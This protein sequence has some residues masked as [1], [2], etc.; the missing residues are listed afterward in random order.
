RGRQSQRPKPAGPELLVELAGEPARPPLSWPLQPHRPEPDLN[1]VLS[2]VIGQR[3]FGRKQGKLPGAP[4]VLVEAL[5]HP[6]PGGVLAVVDLAEVQKRL[7][8]DPAAGTAP[9][10]DDAPVA[11][12]LAVLDPPREAQVHVKGFYADLQP[13]EGAWSSLHANSNCQPLKRL[14]F[15]PA[16]NLKNPRQL[17]QLRKLGYGMFGH[18]DAGVLHVR[19]AIDTKDPAQEKLIREITEEVV[20]L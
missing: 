2:G 10:L 1:A 5:D 14:A 9:A 6:A 17:L 11:M 16:K 7:L 3:P 19:P 4:A 15:P 20:G 12:R 18:V 8:N 13:W